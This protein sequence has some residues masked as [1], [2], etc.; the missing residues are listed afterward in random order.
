[1]RRWNGWGD[2]SIE[3]PLPDTASGYLKQQIGPGRV[4]PDVSLEAALAGV[5]ESRLSGHR[6]I[7]TESEVRLRHARGQSL[8]DWLEL[9]SGRIHTF[10]DGVAYPACDEDVRNLLEYAR[11]EQIKVI[12]YGGGTSVVG[13]INPPDDGEPCL[14]MDL[15]KMNSLLDLDEVSRL[16]TFQAGV[17]GPDLEA[18]LNRLGY[19]LGHFPQSFEQSTLGGWIATRSSGQQ[20]YHYGRIEDLFAGGHVETPIGHLDLPPLPASAAGPDLKQMILGSEG[21][22]GVVTSATV[23]ASPLPK[24]ENFYGI[25]FPEWEAGVTAVRLIAQAGTAV[26]MMRLSDPLE[27]QT[28][29]ILSGKDDLV[30]W[31]DRGLRLAGYR[32]QRCL[33]ILGITGESKAAACAR[34]QALAITRQYGGLFTGDMIGKMWKKSRF[35][36]PYLRNSL[37]ERGYAIDTLET[38][39]PWSRLDAARKAILNTLHTATSTSGER[40]L[41]FSHLSHVYKDGVSAYFTY[42]FR[43][44]T[45]PVETLERWQRLKAL[46]SEDILGNG[47]TI[48]H[49]HGVGRDHAPYLA[50][51]K[52]MV[53]MEALESMIK[54]VDPQAI[55]NPGKLIR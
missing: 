6:F 44:G 39:L 47:G 19:T 4:M 21:R 53:G 5:P 14:C 2:A 9:R 26:S 46:A 1:M 22:L 32:S 37:W 40:V 3:Y 45:D 23:R 12:P 11:A 24:E 8:P 50:V 29:L 52:G 17:N 36:T 27:T 7:M 30:R 25:F 33:L 35:Y 43:L 49:Q 31:A 16:A 34:R 41:A 38:A 42:L 20:S 13:H 15:S 55:L 18:Q 51:E 48:S 10:P 54:T 28:T